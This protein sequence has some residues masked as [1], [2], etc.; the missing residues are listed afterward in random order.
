[1]IFPDIQG[2]KVPFTSRVRP[3]FTHVKRICWPLFTSRGPER[4]C[5]A[6]DLRVFTK[7]AWNRFNSS[8]FKDTDVDDSV[9]GATVEAT[10]RG[11][12]HLSM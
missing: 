11:F 2:E 9:A 4:E 5:A 10:R 12:A 1:M 3:R 6:L 7:V 8:C